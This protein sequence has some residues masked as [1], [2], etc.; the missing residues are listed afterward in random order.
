MVTAESVL[1][2][3]QCQV[4]PVMDI[5]MPACR[6]RLHFPPIL[7]SCHIGIE[8]LPPASRQPD[9]HKSHGGH[10][11]CSDAAAAQR[12]RSAELSTNATSHFVLCSRAYPPGIRIEP[13]VGGMA[14]LAT[15]HAPPHLPVCGHSNPPIH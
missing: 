6:V 7:S 3:W 11:G 12:I 9:Q 15:G 4:T 8:P 2:V 10:L 1:C 13:S 14:A 5:L